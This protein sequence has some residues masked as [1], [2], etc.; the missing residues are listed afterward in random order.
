MSDNLQSYI[1][2][3][4]ITVPNGNN[5]AEIV[6]TLFRFRQQL[7]VYHW[8]TKIHPRHIA[9]DKYFNKINELIDKFVET[10][11]GRNIIENKNL[12]YRLLVANNNKIIL[13]N[14]NDSDAFIFLNNIKDYLESN[15][16]NE[17]I[18][19]SSD[20]QNIRDEMLGETNQ[21]GYLF[22]LH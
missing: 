21:L 1:S 6:K 18:K 5:S 13:E 12:N 7:H 4:Q 10:L 16:L 22:S 2:Q 20:L 3:L 11:M 9:T 17:I 19:K 14:Y 15:I 8:Q